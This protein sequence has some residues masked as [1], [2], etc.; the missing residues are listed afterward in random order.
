MEVKIENVLIFK[1]ESNLTEILWKHI[2]IKDFFNH[3]IRMN[4]IP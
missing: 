4:D 3:R 2:V 1:D